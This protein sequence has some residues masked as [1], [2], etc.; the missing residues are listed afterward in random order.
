MSKGWLGFLWGGAGGD[1]FGGGVSR[2]FGFARSWCFNA[3]HVS[4]SLLYEKVAIATLTGNIK[5]GILILLQ[6][7]AYMVLWQVKVVLLFCYLHLLS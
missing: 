2:L 1:F 7:G 4:I 3:G 5:Y 6:T